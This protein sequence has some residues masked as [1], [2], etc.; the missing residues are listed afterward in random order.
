MTLKQVFIVRT[1]DGYLYPSDGDVSWTDDKDRA[2][3]FLSGDEAND[4]A[5][6]LGYG[7]GS[8]QVI[9]VDVDEN[10]LIRQ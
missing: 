9:P 3:H 7:I 4:T 10:R 6:A 2:G 8:F 1:R 5:Q